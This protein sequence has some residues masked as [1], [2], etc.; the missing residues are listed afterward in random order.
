MWVTR[1]LLDMQLWECSPCDGARVVDLI[2]SGQ[3]TILPQWSLLAVQEYLP[4][5]EI[6]LHRP[7][8]PRCQCR[9]QRLQD[10]LHPRFYPECLSEKPGAVQVQV[11]CLSQQ[12]LEQFGLLLGQWACWLVGEWQCH[13]QIPL[14]KHLG[15][16][17]L[18]GNQ[19]ARLGCLEKGLEHTA[20]IIVSVESK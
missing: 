20:L 19:S 15:C 16:S 2:E 3:Y 18:K 11:H 5:L 17:R 13:A 10:P 4:P 8:M 12:W 7:W 9:Q 14:G 1:D 6:Y